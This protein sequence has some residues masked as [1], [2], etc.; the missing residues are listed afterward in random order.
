[1]KTLRPESTK[2]DRGGDS[3]PAPDGPR[4]RMFSTLLRSSKLDGTASAGSSL[5]GGGNLTGAGSQGSLESLGL[6]PENGGSDG[7]RREGATRL[8]NRTTDVNRPPPFPAAR[9]PAVPLPP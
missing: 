5:Y 3:S 8:Q 2:G 1:M 4:N 6:E 7:E 9:V